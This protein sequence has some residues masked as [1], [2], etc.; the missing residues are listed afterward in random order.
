MAVDLIPLVTQVGVPSGIAIFLV[1]Y[2]ATKHESALKE[3]AKSHKNGLQQISRA[4]DS[5][6]EQI[7]LVQTGFTNQFTKED[8]NNFKKKL[9]KCPK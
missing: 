8:F 3:I 4:I 7:R 6:T 1:Y 5:Q 9:K 2:I